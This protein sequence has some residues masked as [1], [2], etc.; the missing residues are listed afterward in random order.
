MEK[1]STEVN[2][3]TP[4]SNNSKYGR[5]DLADFV[6]EVDR[7]SRLIEPFA[8]I[9]YFYDDLRSWR[10]PKLTLCLWIVCNLA[11][12]IL[13][14]GAVFVLVS[15]LVVIIAG[16]GLIQIHTRILDKILPVDHLSN[17]DD[18]SSDEED[19]TYS[20]VRQFRVSII[21]MYEFIVKCNELLAH[22]YGILKWDNIL[23]SL[24][25]HIEFCTLLLSLV[26]LPTRWIFIA[27]VNWVFLNNETVIQA[28]MDNSHL[29]V[30]CLTGKALQP[31]QSK[32]VTPQEEST[33]NGKPQ[34]VEKK[35]K[36]SDDV[37]DLDYDAETIEVT[38]EEDGKSTNT[39]KPGMV[40]RLME[41]KKRR[42]HIANESC[43]ACKVS[44]ASILKRRFYCRHCGNNFCSKCCNQR[45]PKSVFGATAPS[46]Q[47][48]TVLVCN[49]CHKNLTKTPEKEKKS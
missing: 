47:T 26:V 36:D 16:S 22:F 13:T 49:V 9:L 23:P 35:S 10:Y 17:P 29:F 43:F 44:F 20:T 2:S 38:M 34:E 24:R 15:L 14:K 5:V 1:T 27:L 11:C 3:T 31:P 42:Q 7:F 46:A 6:K 28:V 48:E 41:L 30:G 21:Q 40:A 12:I 33:S 8:F 32:T 39:N 25:F 18:D 45:V 37:S 4:R 19:S